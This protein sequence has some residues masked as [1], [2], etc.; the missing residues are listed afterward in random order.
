MTKLNY[1]LI[2]EDDVD[3]QLLIKSAFSQAGLQT[4]LHFTNNGEE[5]IGFLKNNKNEEPAFILLDLNMPKMD[6]NE[7][8]SFI[9]AS[10]EFRHIPV[11]VFTTSSLRENIQKAYQLGANSYI[12]KPTSFNTL[13]DLAKQI[14]EYWLNTIKLPHA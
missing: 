2:A 9:R 7:C 4:T 3:D 10:K 5:L 14:N 8:L 12:T 1:I 13:K 11:I 6:G